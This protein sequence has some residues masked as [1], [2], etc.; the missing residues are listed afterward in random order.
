MQYAYYISFQYANPSLIAVKL[1]HN[2]PEFLSSEPLVTTESP[3]CHDAD[4]SKKNFPASHLD[5]AEGS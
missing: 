3:T 1:K 5:D 4:F 2:K